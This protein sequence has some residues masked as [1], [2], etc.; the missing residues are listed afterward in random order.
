MY[1]VQSLRTTAQNIILLLCSLQYNP[2]TS[3]DSWARHNERLSSPQYTS[4]CTCFLRFCTIHIC[5]AVCSCFRRFGSDTFATIFAFIVEID[6]FSSQL[7]EI[8]FLVAE[9]TTITQL[10]HA[11]AR[12]FVSDHIQSARIVARFGKI[13]LLVTQVFFAI[14]SRRFVIAFAR[15]IAR[16]VIRHTYA[17]H[18]QVFVARILGLFVTILAYYSLIFK[19]IRRFKTFLQKQNTISQ[20]SQ[21]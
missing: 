1:Y 11:F 2:A 15:V 17:V 14:L 3:I 12:V 5:T 8:L 4:I 18:A 21:I 10:A 6:Y 20:V 16:F 13:F 19:K 7:A 9:C